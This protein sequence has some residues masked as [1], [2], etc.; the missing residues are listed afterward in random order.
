MGTYASSERQTHSTEPVP[1]A[2]RRFKET[3]EELALLPEGD[4]SREVQAALERGETGVDIFIGANF[5]SD[6]GRLANERLSRDDA[7]L[8]AVTRQGGM[9]LAASILDSN[10]ASHAAMQPEAFAA[11]IGIG[12]GEAGMRPVMSNLEQIGAYLGAP[13]ATADLNEVMRGYVRGE[14][15]GMDVLKSIG[16]TAQ[17]LGY[18]RELVMLSVLEA[19]KRFVAAPHAQAAARV[20]T[21]EAAAEV[22]VAQEVEG[23][24]DRKNARVSLGTI[25]NR[26]SMFLRGTIQKNTGIN[27]NADYR[28]AL[29]LVRKAQLEM[30]LDEGAIMRSAQTRGRGQAAREA[31]RDYSAALRKYAE[32][33]KQT[34]VA[35]HAEQRTLEDADRETIG[36]EV[37]QIEAHLQRLENL[38]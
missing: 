5:R 13:E 36:L 19:H 3:T 17:E 6:A 28:E 21:G 7:L 22:E 12:S 23:D 2:E 18:E 33:L 35:R 11:R 20:E 8:H 27:P 26:V 4:V 37:D 32:V 1:V 24:E 25:R 38:I 30:G 15:T 9:R 34:A 16:D 14:L 10:P 29:E 31:L